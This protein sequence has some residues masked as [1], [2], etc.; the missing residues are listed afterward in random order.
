MRFS[1]IKTCCLWLIYKPIAAAL[2]NREHILEE[3]VSMK[4]NI[5]V[6]NTT[7]AEHDQHLRDSGVTLNRPKNMFLIEQLTSQLAH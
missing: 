6:Y 5:L 3:T 2:L 1:N 7:Q 4:D